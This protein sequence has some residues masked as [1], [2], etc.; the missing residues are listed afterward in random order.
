MLLVLV[1]GLVHLAASTGQFRLYASLSS[2]SVQIPI[3]ITQPLQSIPITLNFSWVNIPSGTTYSWH[4]TAN[5]GSTAPNQKSGPAPAGQAI[6]TYEPETTPLDYKTVVINLTI[7]YIPPSGPSIW[8]SYI[9]TFSPEYEVEVLSDR[10]TASGCSFHGSGSRVYPSVSP[11]EIIEGNLTRYRLAGWSVNVSGRAPFTIG[12]SDSAVVTQ[13][14]TCRAIWNQDYFVQ[15]VGLGNSTTSWQLKGSKLI[16]TSP[17]YV[18]EG[19]GRRKVLD[20]FNVSGTIM[21]GNPCLVTVASPLYVTTKYHDEIYVQVISERGTPSGSGWYRKGVTM[22][23]SVDPAVINDTSLSRWLFTGWNSTLPVVASNPITV[24]AVWAREY[25]VGINTYSSGR[26]EAWYQKGTTIKANAS[27]PH[28]L[29]NRTMSVF[30]SWSDGSG[31]MHRELIVEGPISFVENRV[32]Y[33]QV[34]LETADPPIGVSGDFYENVWAK[35]GSA[36]R[37]TAPKEFILSPVAKLVF[38]GFRKPV[39]TNESEITYTVKGPVEISASWT[40]FFLVSAEGIH[41]DVDGVGWYQEGTQAGLRVL[42]EI[43]Y[44]SCS[45]RWSFRGWNCNIPISVN[46]AVRAEAL[47]NC[48]HLVNVSSPFGDVSGAGWYDA[49]LMANLTAS[50]TELSLANGSLAT[51]NHWTVN[52]LPIS[53]NTICVDGPKDCVAVWTLVTPPPSPPPP[54][55]PPPTPAPAPEPNMNDSPPTD[56]NHQVNNSS[57]RSQTKGQNQTSDENG[58]HQ[59]EAGPNPEIFRLTAETEFS[60]CSGS[61]CYVNGS[62]A[63]LRLSQSIVMLS[64]GDRMKFTGWANMNGTKVFGE[65]NLNIT[66]VEDLV[67]RAIWIREVNINGQWLWENA[68]VVLVAD[69]ETASADGKTLTRFRCWSLK[70]GSKV[71]SAEI[72]VPA[73]EAGNC[74]QVRDTYY[75]VTF[76]LHGIQDVQFVVSMDGGQSSERATDGDS[77]WLPSG[78][79]V[80]F[81]LPPAIFG[82][83]PPSLDLG[84]QGYA[85]TVVVSSLTVVASPSAVAFLGDYPDFTGGDMQVYTN[86]LTLLVL[87]AAAICAGAI[88]FRRSRAIRARE[89]M[90]RSDSAKWLSF[91]SY[92]NAINK[93]KRRLRLWLG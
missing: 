2:H 88:A 24:A 13:V 29:G 32:L 67:L 66:V 62:I 65:A 33:Y 90:I 50:P 64:N 9:V 42:N 73:C 1:L 28:D 12:P 25:W 81:L 72:T 46:A 41:S 55:T 85:E 5:H 68:T 4:T 75:L 87:P 83:H 21:T 31:E 71:Y 89:R 22:S 69:P 61:G 78:S 27:A 79:T 6:F 17:Q 35:T 10:G 93:G 76:D 30:S 84:D 92:L 59:P 77:I 70:N 44:E 51:F 58:G 40:K 63:P 47:W 23:P 37:I 56:P 43:V 18:S 54:V 11:T 16:F 48:E 15:F 57:E 8:E 74:S 80:R 45:T 39:S 91:E 49:G 86:G 26:I 7:R 3:R 20:S 34:V 82:P 60:S 52:G 19:Q 14:T 53:G 38:S 36:V